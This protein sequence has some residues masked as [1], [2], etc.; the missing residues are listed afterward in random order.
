MSAYPNLT[1]DPR[2]DRALGNLVR[3]LH[4]IARNPAR[5][6]EEAGEAAGEAVTPHPDDEP[7]HPEAPSAP[8][9][10]RRAA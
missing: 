10:V 1:G 8:A 5:Q 2:T 7:G 3:L 9:T 4:E 6:A